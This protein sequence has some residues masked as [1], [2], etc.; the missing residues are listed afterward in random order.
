MGIETAG[1]AC[2]VV[3]TLVRGQAMQRWLQHSAGTRNYNLPL[4]QPLWA[5]NRHPRDGRERLHRT[6]WQVRFG[7]GIKHSLISESSSG[8]NSA[9]PTSDGK[10][11][12]SLA[13]SLWTPPAFYISRTT[14]LFQ[15]WQHAV[16]LRSA[17]SAN[18]SVNHVADM[19][20]SHL[21]TLCIRGCL[22]LGSRPT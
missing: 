6:E 7:S 22:A 12:F 2:V 21:G 9:K 5:G 17:V 10:L 11:R 4:S 20:F 16:C 3:A 14:F 8:V 15:I 19:G 18:I 1:W 13:A